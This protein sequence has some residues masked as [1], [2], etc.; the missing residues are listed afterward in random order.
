MFKMQK[1][2][3]TVLGAK[4]VCKRDFFRLPD[5]FAKVLVDGS[6]QCHATS[7][8]KG[9]LD[10][11]WDV[12]YDLY[13]SRSDSITISVWNQRKIH[14]KS[15]GGGFLGCCTILSTHISRLKNAGFQRLDLTRQN[16]DQEPVRGQLIVKIESR[17]LN[18]RIQPNVNVNDPSHLTR[19]SYD[20]NHITRSSVIIEENHRRNTEATPSGYNV[21]IRKDKPV[22]RRPQSA[23]QRNNRNSLQQTTNQQK[24]NNRNSL[25][26]TTNQQKSSNRNSL[27]ISNSSNN[28][29]RRRR[30]NRHEQEN[31]LNKNS[32]LPEG[33][34]QRITDKGQVCSLFKIVS[35][36]V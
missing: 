18:D 22:T 5:P 30:N 2:K 23:H 1:V 9:T 32:D 20:P 11:K 24:N 25:Q 31:N 14:K 4:N 33:Y 17:E 16:Q 26:Q 13:V 29:A 15:G 8:C 35:K 12:H 10:P 21:P 28:N 19:S 6:G 7:A 3:I 34:E 27:Q 36:L